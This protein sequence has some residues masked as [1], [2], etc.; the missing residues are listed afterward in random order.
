A[1]YGAALRVVSEEDRDGR[2]LEIR[3]ADGYPGFVRNLGTLVCPAARVRR[4]ARAPLLLAHTTP[5][6][7][8]RSTDPPLMLPAGARLPVIDSVS[9]RGARTVE[10]V[11]GAHGS[12]RGKLLQPS[13]EFRASVMADLAVQFL[14]VPYLWG[15]RT[16]WGLDCSGLVQLSAELCGR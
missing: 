12:I 6:D 15:G 3:T 10:L 16:S 14:G 2:W 1:A 5:V 9:R 11:D 8:I 13:A 4:F 7:P